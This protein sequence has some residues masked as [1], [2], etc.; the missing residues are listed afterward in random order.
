M[1]LFSSFF[2]IFSLFLPLFAFKH[3][4][5]R[6]AFIDVYVVCHRHLF[7]KCLTSF[8]GERLLEAFLLHFSSFSSLD[9]FERFVRFS[10]LH[11][12]HRCH[13]C[14]IL[15]LSALLC[16]FH[17]CCVISICPLKC[18]ELSWDNAF[19]RSHSNAKIICKCVELMM[20]SLIST[21]TFE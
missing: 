4:K 12:T 15:V 7:P 11:S 20:K 17:R 16:L 1:P 21:C 9:T 13:C 3:R 2:V 10:A 8:G 18:F 14:A 6:K 19:F 5:L